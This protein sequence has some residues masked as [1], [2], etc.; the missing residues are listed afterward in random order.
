MARLG[1]SYAVRPI[2]KRA[3]FSSGTTVTTSSA[4]TELNDTSTSTVTASA[5]T[6]AGATE[7]NDTSAGAIKQIFTSSAAATEGNDTSSATITASAVTSSAV[8]EGNDTSSSSVTVALTISTSANITESNDTSSSSI[9]VT[10]LGVSNVPG[11]PS[12]PE[13]D[14][15]KTEHLRKTSKAINGLLQGKM[16]VVTSIT[17]TANAAFTTLTDSR[18]TNNSFI[19][20]MPVTSNA[21]AAVSGLYVTNQVGGTGNSQGS[22][23]INHANNA[24][25]D[26][27]FYVLII[28]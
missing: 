3:T 22:A 19:G 20:F 25:T 4:V 10:N 17:L 12:V 7:L 24:Q 16:N 28:G 21:A 15:N 2:I 27:T 14:P 26:K 18:I 23:T 5:V 9:T 8:V 6:S 13:F 11:Y 1:R